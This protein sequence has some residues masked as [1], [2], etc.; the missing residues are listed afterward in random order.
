MSLTDLPRGALSGVG[1]AAATHFL[2]PGLSRGA[3]STVVPVSTV[4]AVALSVLCGVLLLADRPGALAWTGCLVPGLCSSR[5]TAAARA[6]R[7][8][9]RGSRRAGCG[10]SRRAASPP[11][12][13][14]CRWDSGSAVNCG[15]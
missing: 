13:C 5:T 2:D 6:R 9:A 12:W 11:Y 8:P 4:T 1:S 7:E 3:M 14:C 10:P 15:C